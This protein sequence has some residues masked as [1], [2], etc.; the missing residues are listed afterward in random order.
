MNKFIFSIINIFILI[1]LF[2]CGYSAEERQLIFNKEKEILIKKEK[3]ALKIAVTPTLDCLPAYIAQEQN[4]FKNHDVDVLLKTFNAQ[5]DCDTAI[6]GK[7]VEGIFSD[8][9]HTEYLKKHEKLELDYISSTNAY[10]QLISNRKARIKN[11]KQLSDKMVGMTRFSATDYFTTK[12]L[13][14]S[15]KSQLFKIQINDI[16]IRLAMLL[17]NEI[18][19]VWLQEPFASEARIKG[20]HV[21]A[22]SRNYK[23]NMGVI[24]FRAETKTNEHRK[25]QISS[26][27]KTYNM[28]CDSINQNGISHYA[29]IIH[30]YCNISTKAIMSIPRLRYNHISYPKESDI[31]IA[32]SFNK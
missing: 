21:I 29:N 10:W 14:G 16:N 8:L 5:M 31:E 24:A 32:S 25:Q 17:N 19:A 9:V 23:N 3:M 27:I 20:N 7:S 26:Y 11:T 2:S 22:D 6:I 13:S 12:A 15:N 30:K 18:D 28:A 1:I 4:M